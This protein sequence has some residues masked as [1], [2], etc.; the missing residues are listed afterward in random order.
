MESRR[1]VIVQ[2][3]LTVD[4]STRNEVVELVIADIPTLDSCL[5]SQT[6]DQGKREF[7]F[8]VTQPMDVHSTV[9]QFAYWIRCDSEGILLE[10]NKSDDE[11]IGW[12]YLDLEE[13]EIAFDGDTGLVFIDNLRLFAYKNRQNCD[14]PVF[15]MAHHQTLEEKNCAI[16]LKRIHSKSMLDPAAKCVLKCVSLF[17]QKARASIVLALCQYERIP[18]FTDSFFK[19]ALPFWPWGQTTYEFSLPDWQSAVYELEN[20]K[21][22]NQLDGFFYINS[23]TREYFEREFEDQ[24]TAF[25]IAHRTIFFLTGRSNES[26]AESPLKLI[27]QSLHALHAKEIDWIV[28]QGEKLIYRLRNPTY[29]KNEVEGKIASQY[30]VDTDVLESLGNL[31]ATVS[32]DDGQA[33]RATEASERFLDSVRIF[34][35]YY[36]RASEM[37]CRLENLSHQVVPTKEFVFWLDNLSSNER[38]LICKLVE[39]D[40]LISELASFFRIQIRHREFKE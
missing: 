40:I 5:D 7:R 22:L 23:E 18:G 20:E 29:Q 25:R 10:S 36:R 24:V 33:M 9:E 17:N 11:L 8:I 32:G 27:D 35:P 30:F 37:A 19:E 31:L 39:N 6:T 38:S 4:D 16:G 3:S 13:E 15:L 26:Q 28:E 21:L 1:T 12:Y 2:G 34:R 14:G